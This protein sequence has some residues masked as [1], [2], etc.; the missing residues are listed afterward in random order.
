M[1]QQPNMNQLLKQAQQMQADMAKAQAQL[2]GES[3]E[4]SAGGGMVKVTMSG[5]MQ[6]LDLVIAPEAIDP[7]DPELLQ[8]MVTAAINEAIRAAQEL[9]ASKMGGITGGLPG[10]GGPGGMPGLGGL[11]GA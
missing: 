5:D 2:K 9:A 6:L 11:P 1:A 8:D 4:A 7:D 3:V 10:G